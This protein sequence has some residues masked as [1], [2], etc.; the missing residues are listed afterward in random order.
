MSDKRSPKF[1]GVPT[2]KEA[3]YDFVNDAVY[4]IV[5]P[6]NLPREIVEKLE[7]VFAMAIENKEYLETL[8]RIDMVPV[9]YDGRQFE[10][11]LREQLG[12]N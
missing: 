7:K 5:G 1:P 6:H 9:F 10:D 8:D 12:K 2:L 4:S 3:G 11:F